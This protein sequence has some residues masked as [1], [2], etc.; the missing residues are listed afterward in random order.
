M[1][2][3]VQRRTPKAWRLK[4]QDDARSL[5]EDAQSLE[6]KISYQVTFLVSFLLL[7]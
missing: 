4:L 2:R 1:T 5:D 3:L 7:L 6:G